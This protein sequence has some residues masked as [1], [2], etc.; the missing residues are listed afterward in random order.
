M[1]VHILD[2]SGKKG[3]GFVV[4]L[5]ENLWVCALNDCS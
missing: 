2:L 1:M 4:F 5:S 3:D